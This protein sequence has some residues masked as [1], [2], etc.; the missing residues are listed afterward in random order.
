MIESATLLD[1]S[2]LG[3][4]IVLLLFCLDTRNITGN[5]TLLRFHGVGCIG[6]NSTLSRLESVD[7]FGALDLSCFGCVSL[8]L[9]SLNLIS[10]FI[11]PLLC[12]ELLCI[13]I[14]GR[15]PGDAERD[16]DLVATSLRSLLLK[17][18]SL[19]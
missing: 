13:L 11:K 10:S 18:R 2:L 17:G 8:L 5:S 15:S 12:C 14:W 19:P 16:V 6:G 7:H 9:T 1:G 3:Y 4:V